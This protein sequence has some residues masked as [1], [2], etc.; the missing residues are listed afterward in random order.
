MGHTKQNV[1]DT[2]IRILDEYGLP[3]LTMRR[4]A[5]TLGVQQSALYWH[6]ESKQL[7]L[8]AMAEEILGRGPE[9]S[10]GGEW[11]T[12]VTAR[13]EALRDTLLA[14]RDGAELVSTVYAFGLGA[15]G[16]H[17]RLAADIG[18]A[19]AAGAAADVAATVVLQFVLGFT[20]SEQQHLQAGSAGAIPGVTPPTDAVRGVEGPDPFRAGVALII[21]GIGARLPRPSGH[22]ADP[23]P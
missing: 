14:Y 3:G 18:S 16:P 7:L 23:A 20:F 12:C 4:L 11:D 6:F 5:S 2:A 19:G 17:R 15:A 8:A 21:D 10:A 22:V 13:A 9:P 1:V